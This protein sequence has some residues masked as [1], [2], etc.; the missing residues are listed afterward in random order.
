MKMRALLA[1]FCLAMVVYADD[2]PKLSLVK[3]G[4]EIDAVEMGRFV[5]EAPVLVTGVNQNMKPDFQ[6]LGERG[7][8]HYANGTV[9]QIELEGNEI[10]C[11]FR[12]MPT[13]VKGSFKF[14]MEI[15]IS[16]S[17]GGKFQLGSKDL[18]EFPLDTA[19]EQFVASGTNSN[20]SFVDNDGHGLTLLLQTHWFGLQDNRI[21]QT[22]SFSYQFLID[23]Q[24][25]SGTDFTIRVEPFSP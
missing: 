25:V 1:W 8:A 9:F 12:D 6:V 14:I 17:E 4:V 21:F 23:P 22:K 13:D 2:V 10:R 11:S 20:F 19:G 3:K 7:E 16:F 15:P 18:Q 5:L 24:A